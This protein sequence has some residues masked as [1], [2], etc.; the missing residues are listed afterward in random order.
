MN[1]EY[2]KFSNVSE[3]FILNNSKGLHFWN[4]THNDVSKN[5]IFHNQDGEGIHLERYS[6]RNLIIENFI[7]E[8]NMG[9]YLDTS[10]FNVIKNNNINKTNG[11][12]AIGVYD[13]DYNEIS[14]NTINFNLGYGIILDIANYNKIFEN[15]IRNNDG[16]GLSLHD[17]DYN[18]IIKNKIFNNTGIGVF[19]DEQSLEN[20]MYKNIFSKNTEKNAMDNGL[21]NA[22]DNGTIGNY[23]ANYTGMDLNDNGIGDIPYNISGFAGSKDNYPIWEDGDDLPPFINIISPLPNEIF[24][25]VAPNFT[26]E[27]KDINLDTMWYTLDGSLTNITFTNNGTIDDAIWNAHANGAVIIVFYARDIYGNINSAQVIIFKITSIP[28]ILIESPLPEQLFGS[29][30]PDFII[31]ISGGVVDTMWYSIDGGLTNFTFASNDTINQASW[32]LMS[33]GIITV[34]FYVN[35]ITDA[36]FFAKVDVIKDT[37]SPLITII[38]PLMNDIFQSAPAFEINVTE[39]HLDT[40]WY[41][42]DNIMISIFIT[43]LNGIIDQEL[44][45]DLP[46]GN[47]TITFY[48]NDTLGNLNFDEVII[49]KNIPPKPPKIPGYD[50]LVLSIITSLCIL[51]ILFSRYIKK[52]RI[53]LGIK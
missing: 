30:A 25:T 14:N 44:W 51:I 6:N 26:V 4:C 19:L 9:I 22:W 53:S 40:I 32:N 7:N 21:S 39:P 3:N 16:Y 31:E 23:W 8:N 28:S 36:V 2:I 20:L 50:L 37:E 47:I 33:D 1:L 34:T 13:S 38:E 42:L 49:I 43:E 10:S 48:A 12:E 29:E 35:D 52:E 15:I 17:A 24:S 41:T 45:E 27:I 46:N 5:V 11:N 18:N